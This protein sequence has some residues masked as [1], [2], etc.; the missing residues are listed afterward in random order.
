MKIDDFLNF[1][2][3]YWVKSAGDILGLYFATSQTLWHW[4]IPNSLGLPFS[5]L[6]V[7]GTERHIYLIKPW[8]SFWVFCHTRSEIILIYLWLFRLENRGWGRHINIVKITKKSPSLL[9]ENIFE[10]GC[11]RDR[12]KNLSHKRCYWHYNGLPWCLKTTKIASTLLFLLFKISLHHH[13]HDK[14][15][16][17]LGK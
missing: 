13:K 17:I 9:N 7:C 1:I 2:K 10:M 6:T 4:E 16:C 15:K 5:S 8:L 14:P 12:R 3:F 11:N